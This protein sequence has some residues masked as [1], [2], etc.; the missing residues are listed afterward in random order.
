MVVGGLPP[1]VGSRPEGSP[2]VGERSGGREKRSSRLGSTAIDHR[3]T[4][5]LAG[6]CRSGAVAA[7]LFGCGGESAVAPR[8]S[9]P[10]ASGSSVER[11]FPIQDGHLYHYV[12]R[13]GSESG[14]LVAKAH[15]TDSTH[16]ELRFSNTTKR[17]VYSAEG[18][19]YDGGAVVLRSPLETGT[20]WPGE[21]GGTTRVEAVDVDVRV[22]AGSYAGCVRTV[23]EGG[24]PAGSR[25]AASYCPGIGLVLLE[26]SA[27][28]QDA[29][30]ELK[31]YGLP[32][33]ID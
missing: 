2:A 14:M 13:E 32:V 26:V 3:V 20:S 23:E 25:Y 1:P 5:G 16:G 21:H 11:F 24:R 15:R 27:D 31:S 10:K 4:Y 8:P 18:V 28:G 33:K 22:E 17:F 19:A 29:R 9:A 12:T 7:L 6:F 30:A